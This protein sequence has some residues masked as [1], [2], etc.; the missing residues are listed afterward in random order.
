MFTFPRARNFLHVLSDRLVGR[1][2]VPPHRGDRLI[3]VQ[4]IVAAMLSTLKHTPRMSSS[5]MRTAVRHA[6]GKDVRF[7]NEAR[8]LMLAGVDKLA[9]A[10]Q[11]SAACLGLLGLL[12]GRCWLPMLVPVRLGPLRGT[13]LAATHVAESCQ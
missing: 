10:V 13:R 7:G 3:A 11:V 12:A 8:A 9:D 5:V 6:S 4:K 2:I 1:L